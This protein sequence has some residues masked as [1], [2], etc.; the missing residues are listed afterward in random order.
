MGVRR[1]GACI[2]A[3]GARLADL[4]TNTL[5]LCSAVG[6]YCQ[7]CVHDTIR[8]TNVYV[9]R[10][11]PPRLMQIA[12][13]RQFLITDVSRQMSRPRRGIETPPCEGEV[14]KCGI[15]RLLCIF[16]GAGIISAARAPTPLSYGAHLY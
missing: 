4:S 6:A 3:A 5:T 10:E 1:L 14:V 2:N 12:K 7:G 16:D 11:Q 8:A 13:R 9:S 15:L